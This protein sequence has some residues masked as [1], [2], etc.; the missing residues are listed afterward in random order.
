MA[1]AGPVYLLR[2]LAGAT[3]DIGDVVYAV[4]PAAPAPDPAVVA[5]IGAFPLG[6]RPTEQPGQVLFDAETT[7]QF[8]TCDL[9]RRDARRWPRIDEEDAFVL[10][11]RLEAFVAEAQES[12]VTT[13]DL[14]LGPAGA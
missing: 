7:M 10:Y 12:L 14:P 2:H 9:V 8:W 11:P 1:A 4:F 5:A 6:C 3:T 13:G